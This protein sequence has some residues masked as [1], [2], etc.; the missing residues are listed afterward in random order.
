[1][2]SRYY[3]GASNFRWRFLLFCLL[4]MTEMSIYCVSQVFVVLLM[5]DFSG[6]RLEASKFF[7]PK[8]IYEC[9]E[10]VSSNEVFATFCRKFVCV[11]VKFTVLGWIRSV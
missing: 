4:Y 2:I 3:F 9:V 5:S 1:M 6:C 7:A 10:T 8:L 11:L